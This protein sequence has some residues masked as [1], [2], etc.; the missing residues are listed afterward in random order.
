MTKKHSAVL[1]FILVCFGFFSA[2]GY[3][4][5]KPKS[6]NTPS[7][8]ALAD[9]TLPVL[10]QN[11]TT[12]NLQDLPNEPVL[13]NVWGSWCQSCMK[14]HPFLMSLKNKISILGINWYDEADKANNFLNTHGNPFYKVLVDDDGIFSVAMGVKGAP[15]S[16]LVRNNRV[17]AQHRGVLTQSIWQAKFL[18]HLNK[19][20]VTQ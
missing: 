16:F 18:P 7:L 6:N 4:L 5:L 9:I 3:A 1:L 12:F 14:E 2:L 20:P 19:T 17:I 15:E 8:N 13:I 11:E 10:N